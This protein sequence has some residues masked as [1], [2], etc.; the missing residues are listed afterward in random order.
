MRQRQGVWSAIGGE[1]N[2][3]EHLQYDTYTIPLLGTYISVH[4]SIHKELHEKM[5]ST[6]SMDRQSALSGRWDS[7]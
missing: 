2:E 7:K 1:K 3:W 6:R 5:V 4:A